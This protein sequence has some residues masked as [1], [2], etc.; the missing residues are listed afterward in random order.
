MKNNLLRVCL[1]LGTIIFA[2]TAMAVPAVDPLLKTHIAQGNLDANRMVTVIALFKDKAPLPHLEHSIMSRV[3][4]EAALIQN[5]R[6]SQA[7]SHQAMVKVHDT[8]IPVTWETLWL[9]NAAVVRLQPAQLQLLTA[10]E[11]I[12]A[13]YDASRTVHIVQEKAVPMPYTYGLTKI[14]L[15]QLRE[16]APTLDGRGVRVGI[17]DTGIDATHPDLKDRVMLFKDFINNK[18]TPYDDNSHGTHVSG[19]ISG[20][21]ASGTTIG[22]APGVKI[23]SGKVFSASGSATFDALFKAMQWIADPDGNPAHAPMLVSNSWGGGPASATKD[24]MDEP[25]CKAVA[26]WVKLGILPVFANGNSGPGAGS[27]GLPGACPQS[28]AVGATDEN[29]QIA[30]FSSRGPATWKSGSVIKPTVSAPGVAVISSVPG[31]GYKAFSGT[32]MA[33]PHVAGLAALVYQ[34]N[35]KITV[36]QATELIAK[37][38]THLGAGA[39]ANNEYGMGRIDAFNTLKNEMMIMRGAH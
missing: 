19:T 31:G 3:Q 29:D 34:A 28:L 38:A 9:F 25:L 37:S 6:A 10:D 12:Y 26:G 16:K 27:V 22:I 2:A 33:T 32:S 11:N 7:A 15:P 13:I 8:G 24:P 30:N 5:A 1:I 17:L 39:G 18:T 36:E 14:N 35:P 23:I 20:G 21:N 4:V